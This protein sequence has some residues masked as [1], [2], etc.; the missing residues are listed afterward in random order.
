[1]DKP[2][3]DFERI[4]RGLGIH[5]LMEREEDNKPKDPPAKFCGMECR[6]NYR[7]DRLN[8]VE[9]VPV[10]MNGQVVS[11]KTM[12]SRLKVCAYCLSKLEK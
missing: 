1:M 9:L 3:I 10:S 7:E 4:N 2:E 5:E 11:H 8:G 6:D 12:C